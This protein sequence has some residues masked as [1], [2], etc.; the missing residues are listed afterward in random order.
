MLLFSNL[1]TNSN[2][3]RISINVILAIKLGIALI[4]WTVLKGNLKY[5]LLDDLKRQ[6]T[7]Y[8][9]QKKRSDTSIFEPK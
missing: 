2:F 5:N 3:P 8:S 6:N 1:L 4:S 9:F 7:E